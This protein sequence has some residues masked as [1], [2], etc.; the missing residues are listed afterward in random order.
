MVWWWWWIVFVVWLTDESRLALFP[1]GTIARDPEA[2]YWEET[3]LWLIHFLL[4]IWFW[5]K[6]DYVRIMT[7]EQVC[8]SEKE[9]NFENLENLLKLTVDQFR[10]KL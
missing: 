7:T 3:S 4:K 8:S 2:Q 1:A 6:D 5:E 9:A 10:E